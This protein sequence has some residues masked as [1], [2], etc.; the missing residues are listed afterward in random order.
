[1]ASLGGEWVTINGRHIFIAEGSTLKEAMA[2][3]FVPS[4]RMKRAIDS[5]VRT[6][7]KEQAIAEKS[8]AVLSRSIGLPRTRDNSAF[9]LRNDEHGIEVKTLVNGK[10]EKIT[11]S[12]AALGRKL[13]EQ[14][15]DGIKVHTVVADRR[16]GGL[17]GPAK[18]YYREGLGSFRLSSMHPV[19]LDQI[20]DLVHR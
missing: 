1:M 9:D 6:G 15:A 17:T 4:A 20:K 2:V 11:M 5:Q 10:N 8:E 18:Y 13:A 19:T 3:A 7:Q 12:K 16:G 14:Q